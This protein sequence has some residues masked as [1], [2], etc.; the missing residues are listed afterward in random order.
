MHEQMLDE[1][2]QCGF[3]VIPWDRRSAFLVSWLHSLILDT[4]RTPTAI[5]DQQDRIISVLAG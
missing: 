2:V 5:I 1:L 4:F 3:M